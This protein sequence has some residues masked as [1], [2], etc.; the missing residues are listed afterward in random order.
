MHLSLCIKMLQLDI[1]TH[2]R[3]VISETLNESNGKDEGLTEDGV[4]RAL[5]EKGL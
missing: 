5:K 2:I 3:D 4:L 1:Q